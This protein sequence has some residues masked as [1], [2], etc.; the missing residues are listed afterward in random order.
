[1]LTQLPQFTPGVVVHRESASWRTVAFNLRY[2]ARIAARKCGSPAA[3]GLQCELSSTLSRSDLHRSA[4]D[5]VYAYGAFPTNSRRVP[6]IF[7]T[8]AIDRSRLLRAGLSLAQIETVTQKIRDL[9]SRSIL[10]TA[11]SQAAVE[12]LAA[13]MPE[14]IAKMRV[15]PFFLPHLTAL[16]EASIAA[17]FQQPETLRLIFVGREARRKGLPE[18]LSAFQSLDAKMPRRLALTVVS[19]FSDGPVDLPRMAN[20]SHIPE[21]DP[22]RI[23][24]LLRQSHLLLMPSHHESYGWVY[25]EAMAAGTIPVASNAPIQREILADGRAGVLT[26]PNSDDLEKSLTPLLSNHQAMEALALQASKVCRETYL[27]G[28]VARRMLAI[29]EEARQLSRSS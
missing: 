28:P 17:K 19:S 5:V 6:V 2:A 7:H 11:N 16:S 13:D 4:S 9:A 29:F 18:V 26:A 22:G 8:G 25:L 15:L 27:P 14:S 12:S 20:V 24:E 21:L 3:I 1:M 10:L 23:Q